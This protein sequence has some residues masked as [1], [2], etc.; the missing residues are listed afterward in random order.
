LLCTQ[1]KY[2]HFCIRLYDVTRLDTTSIKHFEL[3]LFITVNCVIYNIRLSNV[4]R[5]ATN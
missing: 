4:N 5:L 2:L 3:A 1:R